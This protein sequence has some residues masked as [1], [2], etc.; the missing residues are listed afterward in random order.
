MTGAKWIVDRSIRAS[1]YATG[2]ICS[3]ARGIIISVITAAV[4]ISP[5]SGKA[6]TFDTVIP[7]FPGPAMGILLQGPII[8][9]DDARLDATITASNHAHPDH[10]L[11]A[12]GLSSDG[13]LISEALKMSVRIKKL[14][15]VTV[16]P[17]G[18]TCASAC[19]L[20]FAS[21]SIKVLSVGSYLGVHG[22][23][24]FNG[25]QDT[26]AMAATTRMAKAFAE[27]GAPASVIGRMVVTKPSE[28]TWLSPQEVAMFPLGFVQYIDRYQF[29]IIAAGYDLLLNEQ[30]AA[31]QL[32]S[33]TP[34]L[35]GGLRPDYQQAGP[36]L[37][38]TPPPTPYQIS[39]PSHSGELITE[40][41]QYSLGYRFG[42]SRVHA[43]CKGEVAWV[44]GCNGGASYRAKYRATAAESLLATQIKNWL[45]A[46][47]HQFRSKGSEG[48]CG[49]GTD[50]SNDGCRAGGRAWPRQEAVR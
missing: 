50:P 13:G 15:L 45:D 19:A 16:V 43:I 39:A 25:E 36:A 23:A 33:L 47:D 17:E 35:G 32:Q 44:R 28:M 26:A 30:K 3:L 22:A 41:R 27:F 34:Y 9:G 2:L 12:I 7:Q 29:P 5:Q 42:V 31:G 48:D 40:A 18:S 14:G 46:Y 37:P 4:G 38:Q 6:A 8:E 10:Y 21:G 1:R 20:L 24:T 11:R 49:N